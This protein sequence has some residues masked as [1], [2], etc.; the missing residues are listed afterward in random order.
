LVPT[1]TE[2]VRPVPTPAA[3]KTAVAPTPAST[4]DP[5]IAQGEEVFQKTAGGVGCQLCH[6]RDARGVIGPDIR[7]AT[8]SRVAL[9]MSTVEQMA[10]IKLSIEEVQAVAAYLQSL[11]TQ[12]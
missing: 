2:T 1:A 6:G 5:L 7:G 9:A 8:V 10:F 3:T 11:A 12:P 4:K